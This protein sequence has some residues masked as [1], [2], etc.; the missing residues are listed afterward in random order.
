LEVPQATALGALV[1]LEQGE[2]WKK[3]QLLFS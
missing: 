1:H 3:T 2:A